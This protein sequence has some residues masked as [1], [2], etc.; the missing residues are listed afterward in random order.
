MAKKITKTTE[1][2]TE[3]FF[4]FEREEYEK[5]VPAAFPRVAVAKLAELSEL[6]ELPE[7]PEEGPKPAEEDLPPVKPG[8]EE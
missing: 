6:T 2:L 3:E 1:Q 8:L 4:A 5:R 7:L